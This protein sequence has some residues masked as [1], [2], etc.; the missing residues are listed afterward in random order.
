MFSSHRTVRSLLVGALAPT[1]LVLTMAVLGLCAVAQSAATD[2]SSGLIN[3]Q[4]MGIN[5]LTRKVYVV[6]TAHGAVDVIETANQSVQS[7]AV[8]AAPVSV[9]VDS[10]SGRAYV[11]NAGDGTVSIIHG[12]SNKV[13]ATVRVGARPY[14]I[15]VNARTGLVYIS[16]TFSDKTTILDG[17]THAVNQL[18]TGSIDLIAIDSAANAAYL[19]AYEGGNLTVLEG[20]QHAQRKANA[21]KHA[22]GMALNETTHTL[23][24]ARMGTGDVIALQG[25]ATS[26]LPAGHTPCAVAVNPRSNTVYVANYA[27]SNVSVLDGS[28]RHLLATIPVGEHPQAIAVDV[29]RN[30]VYVANTYSNTV[31]VIDGETRKPV[32]TLPAGKAPYAIAVEPGASRIYVAN[33]AGESHFTI[34]DITLPQKN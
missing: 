11:A 20:A 26:I 12:T 16:H 4:A 8:G 18:A 9:A 7:I 31:T 24:V 13:L 32:A 1:S 28:T 10:A 2:Q 3:P 30:L 5:L 19:L 21:G 23:Y 33:E 17:S 25:T 27:G 29:P 14:S 22:W 6:D 34:V 15:A